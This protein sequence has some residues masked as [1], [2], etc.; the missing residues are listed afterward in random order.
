MIQSFLALSRFSFGPRFG[1]VIF[2]TFWGY[3][4]L[5]NTLYQVIPMSRQATRKLRVVIGNPGIGG[6][7]RSSVALIALH[8]CCFAHKTKKNK[9][10]PQRQTLLKPGFDQNQPHR[11][12]LDFLSFSTLRFFTAS[13]FLLKPPHDTPRPEKL[14]QVTI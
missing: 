8:L 6:W 5:L 4:S 10:S 7:I 14:N 2:C 3:A 12:P 11:T 1:K 9:Y 13:C